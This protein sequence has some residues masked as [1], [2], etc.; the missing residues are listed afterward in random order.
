[1]IWWQW[2][3]E[4]RTFKIKWGYL[5][6][7]CM[8][9]NSKAVSVSLETRC[10]SH[11]R[12]PHNQR[13]VA[14]THGKLYKVLALLRAHER[15]LPLPTVMSA[16]HWQAVPGSNTPLRACRTKGSGLDSAVLLKRRHGWLSYERCHDP[17][18]MVSTRYSHGNTTY[19]V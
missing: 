2:L 3:V 8:H 5:R 18:S 7:S 10:T 9:A 12:H 6:W 19:T 17:S 15:L 4:L 16:R 1:M 11:C 13:A 14:H